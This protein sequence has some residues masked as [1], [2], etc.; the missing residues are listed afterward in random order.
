MK[1]MTLILSCYYQTMITFYEKIRSI[2]PINCYPYLMMNLFINIFKIITYIFI[3]SN[4][5]N[6]ILLLL[7]IELCNKLVTKSI[8]I[9]CLKYITV[10]KQDMLKIMTIMFNLC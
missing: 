4:F 10:I 8:H 1:V 2:V 9:Q 5:E 3:I 6:V 7:K